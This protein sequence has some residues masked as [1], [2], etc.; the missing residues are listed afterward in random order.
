MIQYT[1]DNNNNKISTI[2]SRLFPPQTTSSPP[3]CLSSSILPP[4][5]VER[6]VP[7]MPHH[8][9]SPQQQGHEGG[10][11]QS[12][13]SGAAPR[14]HFAFPCLPL[15]HLNHLPAPI[16]RCRQLTWAKQ[17]PNTP[18]SLQ[19]D[20]ASFPPP[21]PQPPPV[22]PNAS[23]SDLLPTNLVSL[24]FDPAP[25]LKPT[26]TR[27]SA[28]HQP[29]HPGPSTPHYP[30]AAVRE[31]AANPAAPSPLDAYPP[32]PL[33]SNCPTA[34]TSPTTSSRPIPPPPRRPDFL[35]TTTHHSIFN[36]SAPHHAAT[37]LSLPSP[38]PLTST[39]SRRRY[40]RRPTRNC[41][42]NQSKTI[43]PPI[44]ARERTRGTAGKADGGLSALDCA[45]AQRSLDLDEVRA[46]RIDSGNAKE[47]AG[48]PRG[49]AVNARFARSRWEEVGMAGMGGR[50]G[51]RDEP[52]H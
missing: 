26:P 36:F 32:P 25:A 14:L 41:A 4:Q 23:A 29:A 18:L 51:S 22:S 10:D 9:P 20:A 30:D 42:K 49:R 28:N 37:A 21:P 33:D 1:A 44:R 35:K 2:P 19:T 43:A 7:L 34:P 13:R 40:A 16:R 12:S 50:W 27:A 3:R 11:T 15:L 17:P 8:S 38:T 6:V 47:T 45:S 5:R 31:A 24:P 39:S 46:S 48:V 52:S